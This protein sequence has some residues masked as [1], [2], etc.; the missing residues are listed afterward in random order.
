M[1]TKMIIK[2]LNKLERRK[3]KHSEKFNRVRKYKEPQQS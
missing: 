1:I 3:D 2:M